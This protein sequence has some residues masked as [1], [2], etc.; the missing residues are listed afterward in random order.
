MDKSF[1]QC[2]TDLDEQ[3]EIIILGSLLTTF[4]LSI[5]LNSAG[6][7]AKICSSLRC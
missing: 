4:E 7:V 1:I 3:S 6:S 2:V 5:I